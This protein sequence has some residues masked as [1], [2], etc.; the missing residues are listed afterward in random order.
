MKNSKRISLLLLLFAVTGFAQM[1]QPMMPSNP[2]ME[3]LMIYHMTE[4]LELTTEQAELFF[5]RMRNHQENMKTL[6][7]NIRK[8]SEKTNQCCQERQIT[9][10]ELDNIIS[11]LRI[12]ESSI[13]EEKERYLDDLKPV[14]SPSQRAKLIFF[15]DEFRKELR[16]KLKQQQNTKGRRK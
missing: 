14:L 13:R 15:E 11:E 5:P 16:L 1:H 12:I 2:Q 6:F 7:D 4:Y 3:G 9:E 10:E 8:L